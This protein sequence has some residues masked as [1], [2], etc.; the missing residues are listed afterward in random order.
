MGNFEHTL[1]A[2]EALVEQLE[3]GDLSLEAALGAFEQ[4]IAL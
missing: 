4:G 3:S 2:L 1:D